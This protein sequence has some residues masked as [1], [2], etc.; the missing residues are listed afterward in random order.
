PST[1]RPR[2]RRARPP[3]ARRPPR[4]PAGSSLPL[5]HHRLR[6]DRPAEARV[7][8][9]RRLVVGLREDERGGTAPE[10]L[11][12]QPPPDPAA[13]VP[14]VHPELV[15]EELGRAAVPA[16]QLVSEGEADGL[17]AVER[18]EE[19]RALVGEQRRPR[20]ARREPL[21]DRLVAGAEAADGRLPRSAH[22]E[23]SVMARINEVM[24]RNPRS[25]RSGDSVV[26]AARLMREE[27][28][29]IVPITDG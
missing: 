7:E 22:G 15:D 17:V 24:T 13:A 20:L 5:P 23:N 9:V 10:Q 11:L 2:D 6:S 27:D 26:D 18:G 3:A 1:A 29:G 28:A 25:V 21:D 16:G 12:H 4:S 8:R 14:L 19:H